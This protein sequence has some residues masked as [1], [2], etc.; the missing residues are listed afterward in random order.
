MLKKLSKLVLMCSVLP[1]VSFAG[2]YATLPTQM[3]L[4]PN[5]NKFY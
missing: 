5:R 1:S 2:W 4:E 3:Q